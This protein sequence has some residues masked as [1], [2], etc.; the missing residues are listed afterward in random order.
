MHEHGSFGLAGKG[1]VEDTKRELESILAPFEKKALLWLAARMP[2]W[3]NSDHLTLLG[4]VAMFLAGVSYWLSRW[5][6]L[7][8]YMVSFWLVVNWFGDSLDGTL[9]RYR[10]RLRPKYGYYVDHVVDMF[11]HMFLLGGLA[12][13]GYM[14]GR[15]AIGLLI[16]FYMLSIN[17]YLGTYALGTFKM[18]Y[19]MFGPT[20][21]R[22]LLIIGNFFLLWRPRTD[23]FGA[24]HLLYDIGGLIGMMAMAL[25]LLISIF[26]NIGTLYN[27]ERLD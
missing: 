27:R 24:N 9:A 7:F 14:S 26:K 23:L 22:V 17:A 2:P 15:I 20:E 1:Q 13:S 3:V 10:K 18:S 6:P 12:L 11:G 8:L 19:W 4:M 5:N 25:V 16:V 21:L